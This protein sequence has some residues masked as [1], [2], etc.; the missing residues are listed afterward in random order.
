MEVLMKPVVIDNIEIPDYFV[1]N[2]G[3][4]YSTKRTTKSRNLKKL[5][6]RPS[7]HGI[8]VDIHLSHDIK[9][10]YDYKIKK[11]SAGLRIGCPRKTALIHKLVMAAFRPIDEYPPIPK[12]DWDR[13]PD[14]AKKFISESVYIN[15]INHDPNDNHIDNLEYATPRENSRQ[16]VKFYDGH[17]AN[18]G[19]IKQEKTIEEETSLVGF[20]V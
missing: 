4:V 20:F 1:T 14:S 13:C 3:I 8:R 18:K 7:S 10:D 11:N 19:K 12:E 16:A 6:L 5:A 17:M 9:F 2:T 15:H